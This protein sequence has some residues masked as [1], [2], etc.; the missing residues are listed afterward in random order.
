MNI[1]DVEEEHLVNAGKWYSDHSPHCGI[2]YG[3]A[4]SARTDPK[5]IKVVGGFEA[6]AGEFPWL[7]SLQVLYAN[8]YKHVCGGTIID[9]YW[10]LTAGH[11]VADT[12]TSELSIVAGDHDL[13]EIEGFEQ[14]RQVS[15]IITN[16]FDLATFY[17][18]I[19]LLKLQK[20]L[21]LLDGRSAPICMPNAGDIFDE[22][23][24]VAG[25]GRLS[26]DGQIAHV[27]RQVT[28]PIISKEYCESEYITIG[29]SQ[30]LNECQLCAGYKR[31]G[32]D[33]CQG[34]SGGPLICEKE[35][36]RFYLCGIV[37][38]GVGCARPNYPGVY[39]KVTCFTDWIKNTMQSY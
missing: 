21:V 10:I 33:A 11:C 22:L 32:K 4:Y 18:D 7:V 39:T 38:W 17:N 29:F 9:H 37:S 2:R 23:S 27:V 30:Y 36:G 25:W 14:R 12:S 35:N 8:T 34:D 6:V 5:K 28:I 15:Q 1:T 19:A 3:G 20:P 26:E 24:L 16:N 13:Y 31:G